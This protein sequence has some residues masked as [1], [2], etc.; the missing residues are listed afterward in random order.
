M[1]GLGLVMLVFDVAHDLFD[2]VLDRY[3]PIGAAILIDDERH[4]HARRL[5]AN[6]Q[7][8]GWHRGRDIEY[9]PANPRR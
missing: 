4:M 6:E 5:H 2:E 1:F 7:I 3:E 8:H 9:G